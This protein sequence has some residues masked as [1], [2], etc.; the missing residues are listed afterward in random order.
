MYSY[1]PEG[2][3]VEEFAKF[4]IQTYSDNSED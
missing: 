3:S 2:G 1:F 4:L